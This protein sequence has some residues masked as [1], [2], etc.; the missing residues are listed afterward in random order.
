MNQTTQN[1]LISPLR[2]LNSFSSLLAC[3]KE[4]KSPVLATGVMDSAKC[5]LA[6]A[7]SESISAPSL[8]VSYSEFTAKQIY[9]DV[10]F[11][12]G[13]NVSYYPSKDMIFY[14]ADV[15]SAELTKQRLK[16]L[17]GLINGSCTNVVLSSEA[18]LD[19]L[20]PPEKFR[21][22]ITRLSVGEE[23]SL[24]A[25]AEKLV[26][27]GYERRDAVEGPGQFAIRGGIIDIFTPLYDHA[28]RIE[29]WGDEVDSIRLVDALTQ[30]SVD[31][32]EAISI[33]PMIEFIQR[34]LNADGSDP[35]AATILDYLPK[36]MLLFLDEPNRITEHMETVEAEFAENVKNRLLRIDS[37]DSR[38]GNLSPDQSTLNVIFEYEY[39]LSKIS[40]FKTVLLA[41]LSSSIKDFSTKD[42][43]NFD[44][45]MTGVFK[46][47][48]ELLSE[49]LSFWLNDGYRIVIL[50]GSEARGKRISGEIFDRGINSAY[51]DN[52][53][54][55]DLKKGHIAVTH[56]SLHKGFEYKHIN[57][58]VIT[59]KEI[60]GEQKKRKPFKKKKGLKIESFTDLK[61][62]DYVVHDN[63]GIAV[64]KGIKQIVTDGIN[65]DYLTLQ[66]ADEGVL[67][68]HTSQMDMIQKYI[69]SES[70]KIK[71]NK[72]GG[73]EWTRAKNRTREAVKILAS[74]LIAL[75]AERQAATGHQFSRDTVWQKEFEDMF[76]YEETEDQIEA[77]ED[78]KRDM[79]SAKV[80]DRLICGDVGY[81][82]TEVA[83][84]A[85]FKAVQD[86]KQVAFL[87]PTTILA[88]QHY[89][90]F[91]QRMKDFPVTIEMLSRFRTKKEQIESI[92]RLSSGLA[93]IVIGTHRLLSADVKFTN[94]GLIVVDEEQRFGVSHKEK[95]KHMKKNVDVLTLTAT[96]IPR[97]LHMSMTGIRDM[98]VLEEPPN[99]RRP[100]QTYVMEYSPE[101]VRDAILR[102]I[103][104][105][106]QVYYLSNRVRNITDISSRLQSI[107]PE[108][109]IS[110]AHGQMSERE[111]ET[112]M[113][114]FIEGNIDVLVCT[115]IIE[116]GLD[117]SNVNT[118]IVQDSDRMGLSQL[119]QL[120]GRVGR[121]NRLAYAYL[122]YRKD[123]ILDEVAEKRLQTIRDFT[124][125]GAGFK[126]AMRD[127][128]IRGAGNLLGGEQHGH[129]DVVGYDMYCK[130][131]AEAVS[132][133]SHEEEKEAAFETTIDV[134]VNAFIPSFYI[135]NEEQKLEIYKKISLITETQ[136]Y[137]DV[138]E[139]IEDRFG[140]LPISVQMLLEIALLK[141][142]AHKCG[143]ISVTQKNGSL[144]MSFKADA[145]VSVDNILKAV[146]Q[147]GGN[148]RL[149]AKGS[150]QLIYKLNEG[151]NI[152]FWR[153]KELLEI[154]CS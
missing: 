100:I 7:L 34:E 69:G 62:G 27:T 11:L 118:I 125:F 140:N 132:D 105:G 123:K 25:L 52:I 45:K 98:S 120:R 78:V 26:L 96:P 72:L 112:V 47:Q 93:D 148:M 152:D 9:D 14:S 144:V 19:K 16:V 42:I 85:A 104:R 60:F 143:I 74:E 121:S 81:G 138:Q 131:L 124:E 116:T 146:E 54:E 17:N 101:F 3:L 57:F 70:A 154:V 102:E 83:I 5:H 97:T 66:Y 109:T 23:V 88:Q 142:Y 114:D 12:T 84:R 73:G 127:L 35:E 80:M 64:Y 137:F 111:L 95:L 79:E 90:T 61:V 75:Y 24:N 99:E 147:S 151:E 8:I 136:D 31:K 37:M 48:I 53:E 30:R 77:I 110:Y 103:S 44:V 87:V 49:D 82:K 18:L 58:I 67:Y 107:V 33:S 15:R 36:N 135:F 50:A 122:M 43:I 41:S 29:L 4:G 94:L 20:T 51:Y 134:N 150:P 2:E 115:T 145:K 141:A 22:Y 153:I 59:D 13:D 108:A 133:L 40:T 119:Y 55:S 117:I 92:A 6:Y 106:G 38:S 91:M 32:I 39:I 21:H 89:N 126:I 76:P 113:M 149:V 129:M 65:R 10:R 130:L 56:G 63:H 139:E 86:G 128:E 46:G 1:S 71:L 28:V 68:I